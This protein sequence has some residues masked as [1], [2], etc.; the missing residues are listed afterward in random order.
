MRGCL[1]NKK[2]VLLGDSTTRQWAFEIPN[3][4]ELSK[5]INKVEFTNFFFENKYAKL[6]LTVLFRFHPQTITS[7][8]IPFRMYH[9]FVDILDSLP[10]TQHECDNLIVM[11][12]PWAHFPQ[13]TRESFIQK[14]IKLKEA[15]IR[16]RTRCPNIPILVRGGHVREHNEAAGSKYA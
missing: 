3:L 9:Y 8:V 2:M 4:L 1:R 10:S 14:L 13:W 6:N 7:T 15:V 5:P 16:L 11:L 12:S